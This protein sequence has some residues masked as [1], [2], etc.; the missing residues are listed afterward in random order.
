MLSDPV[1]LA[2]LTATPATI[3]AITGLV[4]AMKLNDVHRAVNSDADHQRQEVSAL[5]VAL[6]EAELE[7]SRLHIELAKRP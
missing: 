3:A 4:N 2:A 1:L 5:R 6:R 7:I